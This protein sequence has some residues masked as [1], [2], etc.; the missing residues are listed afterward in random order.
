MSLPNRVSASS[1]DAVNKVNY[2]SIPPANQTLDWDNTKLAAGV[3]DISALGQT[4]PRFFCRLTLAAT[5]GALVLNSWQAQWINATVTA[6][7]LARTSTGIFTITL[8]TAVSDEYEASLGTTLNITVNL[9]AAQAS[10]ESTVFGFCNCSASGNVIT[11]HTANSGGSANDL[12]S[13]VIMV[14]AY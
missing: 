4:A 6:P 8:P 5:T 2:A 7:I 14:V 11:I 13:S 10:L 1:F 12:A 3:S 9:L